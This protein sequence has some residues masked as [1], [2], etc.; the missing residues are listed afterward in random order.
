MS[1][2]VAA[3]AGGT[4]ISTGQ[5]TFLDGTVSLGSAAVTNGAAQLTVN[6]LALGRHTLVA[7]YSGAGLFLNSQSTPILVA[8]GNP[9]PGISS[10][11]PLSAEQNSGAFPLTVNGSNFVNGAVVSFNG[12]ALQTTLVSPT[13]LTAA[14]TAADLASSGTA[15][16][17]VANPTP[18]GGNSGM[19]L[20][21]ID[22]ATQTSVTLGSP[23]LTVPAGQSVTV[24]AQ[25]TGFTGA[26]AVA[27]LNAPAGVTCAF[28]SVSNTITIQTAATT[29]KGSQVVTLVFSAQALASNVSSPTLLA[30]S[31]GV[32][33]L[34]LGSVLIEVRRR[35]KLKTPYLAVLMTLLL[36]LIV[37]CGGYGSSKPTQSNP[38][39]Q[40]QS[41]QASASLTLTVEYGKPFPDA[42]PTR[43][44]PQMGPLRRRTNV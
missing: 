20:F 8:V 3:D 12:S 42:C 19:T 23:T 24:K 32:L 11:N 30:T 26:I 28:D 40:P 10:L 14:I 35:R 43:S 34:P 22:T 41:A 36:L 6:S 44:A 21:A 31:V 38:T 29:P 18:G 4:A 13:Q 25:P 9:V 27:C 2:S 17:T 16:L 15:T 7:S 5:V 37:G 1:A 39:P 33:G